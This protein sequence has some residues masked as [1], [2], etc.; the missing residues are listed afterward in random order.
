MAAT[1]FCDVEM[2]RA[3]TRP[4]TC[5]NSCDRANDG[6]APIPMVLH[7]P[8]CGTQHI[9]APDAARNWTNPPHRSHE[10]QACFFV[11]RA[12]DVPTTGVQA[13]QTRGGRDG[14]LA[15]RLAA[16]A[17]WRAEFDAL[18]D[19]LQAREHKLDDGNGLEAYAQAEA[20]LTARLRISTD[21]DRMRESL[22]NR[23]EELK[24]CGDRA[25][26]GVI[27]DLL[28]AITQKAPGYHS[29]GAFLS[30]LKSQCDKRRLFYIWPP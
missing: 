17:R 15:P 30:R 14:Y 27:R 29:P 19:F 5:R 25:G 26:A 22:T 12:A 8:E 3:C 9:D 23:M 21:L 6:P 20:V 4:G 18:T 28:E 24:R 13:T 7:C 11:W 16:V 10:C 1:R 2:T